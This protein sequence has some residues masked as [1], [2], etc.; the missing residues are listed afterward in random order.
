MTDSS[1]AIPLAVFMM[2]SPVSGRAAYFCALYRNEGLFH[3]CIL[4][5]FAMGSP[6]GS[7]GFFSSHS[8]RTKSSLD[9][10]SV[11]LQDG[12][13]RFGSGSSDLIPSEGVTTVGLLGAFFRAVLLV[14]FVIL[15]LAGLLRRGGSWPFFF[16]WPCCLSPSPGRSV[17]FGGLE[18]IRF[19]W[20][21]HALVLHAWWL[22]SGTSGSRTSRKGLLASGQGASDSLPH[23]SPGR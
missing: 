18:V 16:F 12:V 7:S 13:T 11:F 6:Y 8:I 5:C 4:T 22:A 1:P 15:W 14:S 23:P 2:G 21:F 3:P 19:T 20:A 9:S 17:C 10:W